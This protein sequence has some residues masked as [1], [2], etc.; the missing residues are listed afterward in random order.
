MTDLGYIRISTGQ[1]DHAAQSEALVK[2]GIKPEHI[3]S[4]KISGVKQ[5]RPG[6]DAL[7]GYAREGDSI[8]VVRLDRLGR[9]LPHMLATVENLQERGI[10]LRSLR[11]GI[12]MTTAGG[13][14][15][16]RFM[17]IIAEYERD[18]LRERLG[19]TRASHEAKGGKWG[20]PTVLTDSKVEDA[21]RMWSAGVS[22]GTIAQTLKMSRT[23]VYRITQDL[24]ASA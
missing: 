22:V 16:A 23:T 13:K 1:Q 18:L 24:R 17:M 21:R 4:D 10:L 19:E 11:E 12:D 9:S 8:T 2:A 20:R 7:L 14:V 6:L 15:I 3:Y 5:K